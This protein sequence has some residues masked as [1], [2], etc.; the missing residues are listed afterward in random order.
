MTVVGEPERVMLC[1]CDYCQMRTGTISAV[2]CR[3]FAD[4]IESRTGDPKIFNQGPN[5]QGVDYAFCQRCGSTVYWEF[6]AFRPFFDV[7]LY[8]IAVGCFADKDFPPPT[9][10]CWTDMQSAWVVSAR[11]IESYSEFP[12]PARYM[13]KRA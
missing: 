6:T 1:H 3:Y 2:A 7:P 5:N 11:G 8:G 4:Q 10:E 12:P 9:L 13:P